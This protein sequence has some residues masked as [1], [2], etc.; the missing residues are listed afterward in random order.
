MISWLH[1]IRFKCI[2]L[3]VG[4]PKNLGLAL[5]AENGVIDAVKPCNVNNHKCGKPYSE[6]FYPFTFFLI[7]FSFMKS[8]H[9]LIRTVN[10]VLKMVPK[11]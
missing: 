6:E 4:H 10:T 7:H 3:S 1:A 11:T 5:F 8:E 9:P 2:D